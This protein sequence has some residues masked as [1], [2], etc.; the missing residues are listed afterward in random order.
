MFKLSHKC[1]WNV[2]VCVCVCVCVSFIDWKVSTINTL[3]SSMFSRNWPTTNFFFLLY[4]FFIYISNVIPFPYFP[5]ENPPIPSPLPLL[6]NLPIPLP[7]PG[8]P[9]H[10]GIEPHRDKGFSSHWWPTRP[11]SA[12]YA[13]GAMGPSMCSLVGGLVSGRSGGY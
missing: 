12:T 9:L 2:C 10:W 1:L 13:A 7:C 8:I 3:P 5:S 4:I 6:T 11:S